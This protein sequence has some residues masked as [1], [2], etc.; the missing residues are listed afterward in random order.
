MTE[1]L[2]ATDAPRAI[3]H[4]DPAE[5]M[6]IFALPEDNDGGLDHEITFRHLRSRS[7]K[8]PALEVSLKHSASGAQFRVRLPGV[9]K[10]APDGIAVMSLSDADA[11]DALSRAAPAHPKPRSRP[12][13]VIDPTKPQKLAFVHGHSWHA[14]G[15]PS[16]RVFDMSHPDSELSITLQDGTGGPIYVIRVTEARILKNGTS[17]VSGSI[18][19]AQTKPGTPQLSRSLLPQWVEMRL[20]SDDFRIIA[21]IDLGHETLSPDHAKPI[22]HINDSPLLS[23][24]GDIAGSVEIER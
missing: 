8:T 22:G 6:L 9:T 10:I 19:L 4:F 11:L 7:R 23:I 20:G 21:H 18:L 24:H 5:D 1:F 17:H 16:A 3:P 15:P 2:L 12:K 14:D 13:Q